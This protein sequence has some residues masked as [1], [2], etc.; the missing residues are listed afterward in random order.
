MFEINPGLVVWAV[1]AFQL[2]FAVPAGRAG[3]GDR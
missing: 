2:F 1:G 3:A